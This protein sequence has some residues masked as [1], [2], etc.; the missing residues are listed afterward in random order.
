VKATIPPE[1]RQNQQLACKLSR[2][3][4]ASRGL[5]VLRKALLP[6]SI[7]KAKGDR[8]FVSPTMGADFGELSTVLN[9]RMTSTQF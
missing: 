8:R 2:I 3:H 9:R 5:R 1:Q 7:M 6:P 4:I